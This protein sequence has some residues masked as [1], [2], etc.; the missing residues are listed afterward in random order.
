MIDNVLSLDLVG[1]WLWEVDC[2]SA[3]RRRLCYLPMDLTRQLDVSSWEGPY[4]VF[5]GSAVLDIDYLRQRAGPFLP[6]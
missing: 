6:S 2:C 4:L 1:Q 3:V 5:P